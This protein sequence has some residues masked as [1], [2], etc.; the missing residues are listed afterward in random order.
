MH[1]K[2][3]VDCPLKYIGQMGQTFYTRYKEHTEAIR[4]GSITDTMKSCK[5]K[6]KG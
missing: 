1:Q 3:C 2:K 5:N 4:N 6:E